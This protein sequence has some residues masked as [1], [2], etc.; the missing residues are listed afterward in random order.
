MIET[1]SQITRRAGLALLAAP[2]AAAA[3]ES[4]RIATGD[5]PPYTDPRQQ[6]GGFVCQR[7]RLAYAQQGITVRFEFLPWARAMLETRQGAFD[8]SCYWWTNA[9]LPADFL[10]SRPIV[11][12]RL[13]WLRLRSQPLRKGS[14]VALVRGYTYP[15]GVAASLRRL[16]LVRQT[17]YNDAAGIRMLLRGRVTAIPLDEGNACELLAP[18]TPAERELLTLAPSQQALDELDGVVV[19][20]RK[21]PQSAARLAQLNAGLAA[22][23]SKQALASAAPCHLVLRE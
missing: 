17:V 7:L 15:S 19:L 9:D 2:L 16:Q 5:Y 13:L 22:T 20:P 14:V 18:L 8:A 23:L 6:D 12:N 11:R 4:L 10:L 3:D 1:P 21:L